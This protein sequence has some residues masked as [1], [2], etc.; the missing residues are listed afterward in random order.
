MMTAVTIPDGLFARA[1]RLARRTRKSRSQLFTEAIREYVA[2]HVQE[3][4]TEAM[5]GVCAESGPSTEEFVSA[6]AR[7]MLE[8][9]EW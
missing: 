2:R 5:N 1:E 6:A 9:S 8:R 7:R 4:I 3:E